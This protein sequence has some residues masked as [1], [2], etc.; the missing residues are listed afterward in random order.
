MATPRYKVHYW[1]VEPYG[2]GDRD[3]EGELFFND[4]EKAKK[5]EEMM[6]YENASYTGWA[7]TYELQ[8]KPTWKEV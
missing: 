7:K 8:T 4:L 1:K 5:F 6:T 2:D 3:D